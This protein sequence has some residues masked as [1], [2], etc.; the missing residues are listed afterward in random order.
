[1]GSAII[2]ITFP[3]FLTEKERYNPLDYFRM[4]IVE[5]ISFFFFAVEDAARNQKLFAEMMR[6]AK[7]KEHGLRRKKAKIYISH[8]EKSLRHYVELFLETYLEPS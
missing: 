4:G 8:S 1:M 7:I 6:K 5:K 3:Y 2:S